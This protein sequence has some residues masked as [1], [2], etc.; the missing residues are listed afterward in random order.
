MEV[1]KTVKNLVENVI[2]DNGY[3]L[4]E[5]KYEKEGNIYFLRIIIDKEP[6][7]DVEDCVKI[8][9]LINPILDKEDPIPDSY[10]LDVCSK[11][12]GN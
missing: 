1:E 9:N 8:S 2:I 6:Y 7:V 10:I 12:R 4:D 11:E 5:V 3:K